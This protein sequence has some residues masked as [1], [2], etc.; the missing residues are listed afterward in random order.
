MSQDQFMA[1]LMK[2]H[3]NNNYTQ[4]HRGQ[5][6]HEPVFKIRPILDNLNIKSVVVYTPE[7]SLTVAEAICAF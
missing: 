2:L 5:L 3:M 6:G 4:V 1:I 7:N